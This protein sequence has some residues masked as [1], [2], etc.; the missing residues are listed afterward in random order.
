MNELTDNRSILAKST[1]QTNNNKSSTNSTKEDSQNYFTNSINH[2][3]QNID[4]MP[5]KKRITETTIKKESYL[6]N[7]MNTFNI[8]CGTTNKEIKD[9]PLRTPIKSNLVL[10]Q[11]DFNVLNEKKT[12]NNKRNQISSTNN[13]SFFRDSKLEII[14][15]ALDFK[16]YGEI[17]MRNRVKFED[18]F[19]LTKEDLNELKIPLGP[20]N[21]ILKFVE[22]FRNFS[23][24]KENYSEKQI[25]KFFEMKNFTNFLTYSEINSENNNPHSAGNPYHNN[26]LLPNQNNNFQSENITENK[27]TAGSPSFGVLTQN[28]VPTPN[29]NN[30][31]TLEVPFNRSMKNEELEKSQNYK[32][33]DNLSKQF[34]EAKINTVDNRHLQEYMKNNA[35]QLS[36]HHNDKLFKKLEKNLKN[37]INKQKDRKIKTSQNSFISKR[38]SDKQRSSSSR[39]ENSSSKSFS[40][41]TKQKKT[42]TIEYEN[43]NQSFDDISVKHQTPRNGASLRNDQKKGSGSNFLANSVFSKSNVDI[44]A[45]NRKNTVIE[46]ISNM[47]D[48]SKSPKHSNIDKGNFISKESKL[49]QNFTANKQVAAKNFNINEDKVKM[50]N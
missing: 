46:K 25:H 31:V 50:I 40:F 16:E 34:K 44:F 4:V 33:N 5:P 39:I 49:D 28:K 24:N 21:R 18:L 41:K 47:Y 6:T 36:P 2:H 22:E 26:S 30:H 13:N 14:M 9:N 37:N 3:K 27:F 42:K 45:K 10:S 35:N 17:F 1:A 12:D 29:F 11:I 8:F 19:T 43:D 20:R 23:N 15:D 32:K 7:N 38:N 48:F